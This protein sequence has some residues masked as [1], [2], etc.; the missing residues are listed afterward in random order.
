MLY[1][2]KEGRVL[3]PFD[4]AKVAA[5]L[6]SGEIRAQDEI[7]N[8]GRTWHPAAKVAR[9]IIAA[10]PQPAASPAVP[11]TA[12]SVPAGSAATTPLNP[13]PAKSQPAPS[14]DVVDTVEE[15]MF[16][17]VVESVAVQPPGSGNRRERKVS[18][19]LSSSSTFAGRPRSNLDSA[20]EREPWPNAPHYDPGLFRTVRLVLFATAFV[21]VAVGLNAGLAFC[22]VKFE[23]FGMRPGELHVL[24]GP[25]SR[26]LAG[27]AALLD[28]AAGIVLLVWLNCVFSRLRAFNLMLGSR[29]F[30]NWAVSYFIPIVSIFTIGTLLGRIWHSS[31]AGKKQVTMNH[32]KP[33]AVVTGMVLRG[34]VW[35]SYGGVVAVFWWM[36]Q[37]GRE[38]VRLQDQAIASRAVSAVMAQQMRNVSAKAL[39]GALTMMAV[40]CL[41]GLAS[42]AVMWWYYRYAKTIHENM[43]A[44]QPS[45]ETPASVPS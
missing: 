17:E 40:A 26:G 2:R 15:A 43:M 41:I 45:D 37:I 16:E 23:L 12:A 4:V 28:L 24:V 33:D 13:A 9:Q 35:V 11:A 29:P 8:D 3:G 22:I 7:S 30:S 27:I 6:R 5:A 39:T 42:A 31:F 44:L 38:I 34:L 19:D 10:E 21:Y 18:A 14:A 20:P 36:L 32:S 1:V 25:T